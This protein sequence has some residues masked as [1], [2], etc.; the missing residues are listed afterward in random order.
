MKVNQNN[1]WL[2][3]M[4]HDRSKIRRE[5][6]EQQQ[7]ERIVTERQKKLADEKKRLE[8]KIRTESRKIKGK[9]KKKVRR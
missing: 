7:K 6:V 4:K 3:E 9:N 1:K 5:I 2:E 8:E